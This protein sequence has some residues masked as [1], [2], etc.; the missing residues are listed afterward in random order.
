MNLAVL[1]AL[2]R[3]PAEPFEG[4]IH[5]LSSPGGPALPL[6]Y[7]IG[8]NSIRVEVMATNAVTTVDILDRHS[9]AVTLLF[10]RNHCFMQLKPGANSSAAPPGPS[11]SRMSGVPPAPAP[12]VRPPHGI[13]PTNFPAMPPP[14]T[15]P[16]PVQGLPP[17]IGPQAQSTAGSVGAVPNMPMMPPE[18]G[19]ELKATG[20]TTNLLNYPCQ[21]Y[22]IKQWGQT[23]E[24]WATDQ[25]L[26]FQNYLPNQPPSFGP[27]RLQWQW[28]E[29]LAA[30]GLFPLLASLKHD[31]GMEQYHFEVQSITPA[32]LRPAELKLFQVPPDY[33]QI[34]ARRF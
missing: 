28:G 30:K 20:D 16:M 14:T 22:E 21:R 25:L 23:M 8:T 9:G 32:R 11:I 17:G 1:A 26:P 13:G 2:A 10:R 5:A 24:I 33:V 15:M 31:N 18:S 6:L 29:L 27:T 3:A 34:P 7:T 4:Y 12:S 19:F